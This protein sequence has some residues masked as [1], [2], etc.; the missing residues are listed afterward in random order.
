MQQR[1]LHWDAAKWM[2]DWYRLRPVGCLGMAFET[3]WESL[4]FCVELGSAYFGAK[5]KTMTCDPRSAG[6]LEQ[7]GE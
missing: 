4:G 3:F 7:M 6:C 1:L 2:L 5:Y